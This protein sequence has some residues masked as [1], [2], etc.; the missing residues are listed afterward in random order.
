MWRRLRVHWRWLCAYVGVSLRL[1]LPDWP[2]PEADA[3]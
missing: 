3:H 2:T 1:E